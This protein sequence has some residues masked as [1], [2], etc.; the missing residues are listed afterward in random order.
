MAL[1]TAD[2]LTFPSRESTGVTPNISAGSVLQVV[3]VPVS[4]DSDPAL[5]L[6]HLNG[7]QH[8]LM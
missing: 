4:P 1:F 8:S 6:E 5:E 7:M 3:G 2:F